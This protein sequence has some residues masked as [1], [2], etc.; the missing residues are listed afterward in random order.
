MQGVFR[1]T[2]GV[3]REQAVFYQ[4][5]ILDFLLLTALGGR[6]NSAEFSSQYW[7]RIQAMLEFLV[8]V[9]DV[10]GNVPMIGDADDGYVVRLS[11]DPDFC[12]YRSL[13]ATGAVLFGRADFKR[14][15]A[16]FDDK[17]RW[18]LGR[19]AE[20]KFRSMGD[21][22]PTML[23]RSF[24]NGGYYIMGCDFDTDKEI[25][26]VAD[27]GPLGYLSIAAHG[28]ADALSFTLSLGGHEVLIDP[29][30]YA[31]HTACV[32][33]D[34][35]RGT[36][37]HNTVRVDSEDQS[38]SGGNFMWIRHARATC[39]VWESSDEADRFVG[40]HDGYKRLRDPVLHEREMVFDKRT[41]RLEISDTLYC[42]AE[43]VAE[44]WWHF[45]ETVD[46]T[47]APSGTI[48]ARVGKHQL[49]L[50]PEGPAVQA[51]AYHGVPLPPRGWV[52]RRFGVKV[53]TTTVV[54]TTPL[55]GAT[56]LRAIVDCQLTG[57]RPERSR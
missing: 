12:P 57:T 14:K 38:L 51:T 16:R 30:T 36:G 56:Q 18:L 29:G 10:K 41:K 53:P 2:D 47:V 26:I 28:H 39:R 48:D 22:A 23:R 1:Q 3:N 49:R 4:Q 55:R 44:R 25:R 34:Y 37:A 7:R 20:E 21:N 17:S 32:W 35:F 46:V 11:Q 40:T 24:P 42:A 6:A 8:S 5:F 13:L 9:M 19:E 43:H 31:Y 27:A 45:A 33:R 15:A 52:S 54:W 50:R